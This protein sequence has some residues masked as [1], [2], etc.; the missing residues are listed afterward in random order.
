MVADTVIA[1][2]SAD[3]LPSALTLLHRNGHGP[4]VRVMNAA[5]GDLAGQLQRAG[6][7][8]PPL[9]DAGVTTAVMVFAPNRVA[10]VVDL[11]QR[12]GAGAIHL[13]VRGN[14]APKMPVFAPVR[15]R[16]RATPP[17]ATSTAEQVQD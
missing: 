7:S 9:L 1:V 2:V 10:S 13:A 17:P 14:P 12:I 5:R 6:V 3:H 8:E 11:F 16:S 15:S 4:N